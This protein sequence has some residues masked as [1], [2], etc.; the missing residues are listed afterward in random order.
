MT[1]ILDAHGSDLHPEPEIQGAIDAA[2]I[3][4]EAII[5]VGQ[6]ENLEK[7]L[8]ALNTDNLP[9]TIHDAPDILEMGDKVVES[10]IKKP[11]RTGAI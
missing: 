4:K 9:V 8:K 2:R 3:Y 7:K 6:K 10:A 5:L 11:Y 1:I